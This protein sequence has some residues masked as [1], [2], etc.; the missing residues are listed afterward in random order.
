VLLSLILWFIFPSPFVAGSKPPIHHPLDA[1]GIFH[2]GAISP[3]ILGSMLFEIVKTIQFFLRNVLALQSSTGGFVQPT[4]RV[5]VHLLSSI[6]VK[7][8]VSVS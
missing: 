6:V 3:G 8:R 7:L 1:C 4:S 5:E 2:K